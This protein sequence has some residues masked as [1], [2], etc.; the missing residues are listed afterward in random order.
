[1]TAQ[2][3]E[4]LVFNGES[5]SMAS[6]PLS[7]YFQKNNISIRPVFQNTSCWRG[8]FGEWEIIGDKLFLTK[9]QG[10]AYLLDKIKYQEKKSELRRKMK[11]GIITTQEYGQQLQK[12][13]KSCLNDTEYTLEKFFPGQEKVFAEW[14]SG[15]ITVPQGNLLQYIHAGYASIYEK[16]LLL[17]LD[18]GVLINQ[19]VYNNEVDF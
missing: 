6:E 11:A 15:T 18:A 3:M 14:F 8:Y 9:L 5:L 2:S 1:M 12:L 13:R 16:S 19:Q 10:R 4:I 7:Q 17:E